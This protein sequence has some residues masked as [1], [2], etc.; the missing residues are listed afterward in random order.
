MSSHPLPAASSF[1]SGLSVARSGDDRTPCGPPRRSH[2]VGCGRPGAGGH[3]DHVR[4]LGHHQPGPRTPPPHCP[5]PRD[6][7][8]CLPRRRHVTVP[9]TVFARWGPTPPCLSAHTGRPASSSNNSLAIASDERTNRQQLPAGLAEVPV[10]TAFQGPPPPAGRAASYHRADCALD[11]VLLLKQRD[12]NSAS[13]GH[14]ASTSSTILNISS[15]RPLKIARAWNSITGNRGEGLL[16]WKGGAGQ[17]LS[18]RPLRRPGPRVPGE[19]EEQSL[20]CPVHHGDCPAE[21]DRSPE[22]SGSFQSSPA[23]WGAGHWG[24]RG[25]LNPVLAAGDPTGSPRQSPSV[26]RGILPHRRPGQQLLPPGQCHHQTLLQLG[27]CPR[28]A[29][30]DPD[31]GAAS[32]SR[33]ASFTCVLPRGRCCRPP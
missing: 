24:N 22:A 32:P 21:V 26:T 27:G 33:W 7:P 3:W 4:A 13:W 30:C 18:T 23:P 11:S 19:A 10:W 9:V 29:T 5:F 31:G 1:K 12:I 25:P 20:C 8:R 15:H 6:R 16:S 14:A 2:R 17:A 28:K